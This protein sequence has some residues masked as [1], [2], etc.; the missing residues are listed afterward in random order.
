M[1]SKIDICNLALLK[2]GAD[3]IASIDTPNSTN[4]ETCQLF[5]PIVLK[6]V[7]EQRDWSFMMRRVIL[8]TPVAPGPSWGYTY[9]HAIPSDAE[10]IIDVRENSYENTPSSFQWRVEGKNITSDSDTIYVRYISN[11]IS[12]LD[13][14]STFVM[15][16]ATDLAA[17]ICIA[18][19]E[20]RNLKN[21]L[22]VEA[23]MLLTDAATADGMQ[24]KS[25]QKYSNALVDVR[26]TI[27]VRY[28]GGS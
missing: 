26:N 21:D 25:E 19:T 12:T 6:K 17:Q 3:K 15:A 14:S 5:Y 2:L 22:M 9:G 28:L 24:G 13:L 4:E 27:G 18:V 16:I 20:N 7:L 11:D 8:S 23:D 1:A 10:R